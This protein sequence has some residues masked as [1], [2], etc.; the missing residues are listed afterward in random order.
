MTKIDQDKPT[1]VWLS[2]E[3]GPFSRMQNVN[4]RNEQQKED[5][6]K[7][8]NNCIR[9]YV[10]GLLIYVHCYQRGI[11]CTWEWS[12]TNDAWRLPMVQRVFQRY[13]PNFCMVKGCRV[14]LR[15]PKGRGLLQTG[16]KLATTHQT[17]ASHMN[18]PCMCDPKEHVRCEG[19]LTRMTAYY[20]DD[21]ARRVCRAIILELDNQALWGE[22]RGVGEIP[23][24]R[25]GTEVKCSCGDIQ[26]PRSELRC[27]VCE[28]MKEKQHP[29]SMVGDDV[30]M[31]EREPLTPEERESAEE[32]CPHSQKFW[33]WPPDS[34]GQVP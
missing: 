26:H 18:L 9:Q 16:W 3:C 28:M 2:L 17:M 1:H 24:E 34:P 31:S 4:Q 19:N 5:L 27:N 23:V 32:H 12:E 13:P 30:D 15:D 22:L 7:K 6:R 14:R 21:F 25:F 8:R 11:P 29:L 10:G 33:P 20:T